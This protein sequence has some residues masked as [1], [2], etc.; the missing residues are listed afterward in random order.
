M[1]KFFHWCCTAICILAVM[2]LTS[3]KREVMKKESKVSPCRIKKIIQKMPG[4]QDRTGVFTYNSSGDP[5]GF[6]P[7]GF[8]TGSV[9]YEFRYDKDRRLTDYIGYYPGSPGVNPFFEFWTKYYFGSDGRVSHDTTYFYGIYGA[10][11]TTYYKPYQNTT[12][13]TF[14]QQERVSRTVKREIRNGAAAMLMADYKYAY[15]EFGNL[16]TAGAN[17]DD[18]TNVYSTNRIWMFLNRNYSKNNVLHGTSYNS[19]GLP[20]GFAR[21]PSQGPWLSMLV[22][23]GLGECEIEYEC[24]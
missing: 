18:K 22:F 24:K 11:L 10:E 4:V 20:L 13:Y 17:Y 14:D 21:S 16:V 5:I 7:E 6:T 8:S 12:T 23:L 1:K 3:C 15:N 2:Q 9:K 19:Y